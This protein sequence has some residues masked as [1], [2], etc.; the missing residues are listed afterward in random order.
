MEGGYILL[1]SLCPTLKRL[2]YIYVDKKTKYAL[3]ILTYID[4]SVPASMVYTMSL[5]V[6]LLKL[7]LFILLA[8][9]NCFHLNYSLF[10]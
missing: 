7:V 9:T 2:V 10:I 3:V 4:L 8:Y 1:V 6:S 5:Y